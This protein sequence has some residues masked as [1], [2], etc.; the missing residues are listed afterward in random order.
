[1]SNPGSPFDHPIGQRQTDAT[2]LGQA[3]HHRAGRPE[4]GQPPN[5]SD[6]RVAVGGERERPVD[7]LLDPGL[8]EDRE[9]FEAD[10]ERG[11]DAVEVGVEQTHPEVPRGLG[12]RP[13]LAALFI[14]SEQQTAA[15]LS[16]VDLTAEVDGVH[17]LAV[18]GV[19]LGDLGD[20]LGQQVHVF[21]G[22]QRQFE[23]DHTARPPGPTG[24]RR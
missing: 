19:V 22:Q 7:H 11:G 4:A 21:H 16:H 12:R 15:L 5:R 8:G 10:V 9:V 2:T 3:G 6:Q 20:V 14:G 17:H 18:S 23:P 13:R 24:H 1:M